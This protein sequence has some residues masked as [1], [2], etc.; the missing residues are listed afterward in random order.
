MQSNRKRKTRKNKKGKLKRKF[1]RE[2]PRRRCGRNTQLRLHQGLEKS[3][4]RRWRMGLKRLSRHKMK[5]DKENFLNY[6]NFN[7]K[8]KKLM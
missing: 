4:G 7:L 1:N 3:L 5:V 8:K 2:N 6:I